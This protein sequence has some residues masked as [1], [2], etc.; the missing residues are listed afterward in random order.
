MTF[1]FFS[2]LLLFIVGGA[3]AAIFID[4]GIATLLGRSTSLVGNPSNLI[5]PA[6]GFGLLALRM[7]HPEKWNWLFKK[8]S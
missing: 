4:A 1:K 2:T 8:Q 6:A 7:V 3:V 5:A